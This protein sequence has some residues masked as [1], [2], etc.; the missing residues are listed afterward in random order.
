V[1][2][3]ERGYVEVVV[4]LFMGRDVGSFMCTDCI[5]HKLEVDTPKKRKNTGPDL[6]ASSII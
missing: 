5:L 1:E 4:Y 6:N 3:G 2:T